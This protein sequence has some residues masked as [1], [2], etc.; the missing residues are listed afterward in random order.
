V[1]S[2]AADNLRDADT[3]QLVADLERRLAHRQ[4][5]G[6]STTESGGVGG[7]R[8]SGEMGAGAPSRPA[9]S[10]TA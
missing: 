10:G 9:A 2:N 6:A 4:P 1:I 7:I 5:A 3:A 8:Q